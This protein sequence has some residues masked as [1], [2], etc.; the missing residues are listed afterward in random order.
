MTRENKG[1]IGFTSLTLCII[2]LLCIIFGFNVISIASGCILS[3]AFMIG[4]EVWQYKTKQTDKFEYED[5]VEYGIVIGIT[6]I[7]Y[8]MGV[9]IFV[10]L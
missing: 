1:I 10:E 8:I 4:R 9:G 2:T 3:L 7:L 6:T 5:V